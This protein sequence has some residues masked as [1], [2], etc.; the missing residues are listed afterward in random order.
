MWQSWVVCVSCNLQVFS[1]YSSAG[2]QGLG[3][4]C[5]VLTY[6]MLIL[7][8]PRSCFLCTPESSAP[9]LDLAGTIVSDLRSGTHPSLRCLDSQYLLVLCFHLGFFFF[10]NLVYVLLAFLLCFLIYSQLKAW[11]FA[12]DGRAAL[13]PLSNCYR[14]T[15]AR[16]PVGE[17]QNVT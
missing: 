12:K 6:F 2:L 15:T 3:L 9:R 14:A 1:Q 4:V 10:L 8:S 13:M 5:C 17:L 11:K 16:L 7:S